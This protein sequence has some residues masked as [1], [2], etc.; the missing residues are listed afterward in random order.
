LFATVL[1]LLK[2]AALTLGPKIAS[3]AYDW[4]KRTDTGKSVLDALKRYTGFNLNDHDTNGFRGDLV[5]IN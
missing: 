3:Y 4:A 2:Q 5:P 1:P